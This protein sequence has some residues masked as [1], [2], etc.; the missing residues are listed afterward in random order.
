M[1]HAR[2]ERSALDG[3]DRNTYLDNVGRVSGLVID[4]DS[5]RLYWA[6]LDHRNIESVDLATGGDRHVIISGLVRPYGLT[7]FRDFIYWTDQATRTIERAHK[8]T[9]QNRTR[10]QYTSADVL[11]I[12]VIHNSRQI[13]TLCRCVML[14]NTNP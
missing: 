14:L 4:F 13:G 8:A 5:S 7:Q 12:S 10:I 2:V 3:A 9:G 1:S 11:D 6:N